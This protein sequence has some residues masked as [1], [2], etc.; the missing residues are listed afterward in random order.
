MWGL[1]MNKETASIHLQQITSRD[2]TYEI[3]KVCSSDCNI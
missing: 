3:P 2:I 1:Y